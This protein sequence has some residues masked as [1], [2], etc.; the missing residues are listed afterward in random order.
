MLQLQ[1]ETVAHCNAA[2]VFCPYPTMTRKRGV[3][4]WELFKKIAED[5]FTIPQVDHFTLTGLGEPLLDPLLYR[6]IRYL[7]AANASARIDVYTNGSMLSEGVVE[8]LA[9]AGLSDLHVSLNA[10]SATK[11][12]QVM[13]LK[14]YDRV[15]GYIEHA[16]KRS[17]FKVYVKG[18]YSLDLM[19]QG[20]VE[21][22]RDK[23]GSRGIL[24]LEGNWAGEKYQS[25]TVP[26][27]ACHRAISQVMVLWDGRVSLCC[28]DGEGKIIFGDLNTQSIREVFNGPKALE[29][30]EGH[31]QGKRGQLPMCD[32][33]TAI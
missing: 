7:R 20:E 2:C 24:V 12:E 11:R 21:R 1:M 25:R 10:A 32:N 29:Y 19:E 8:E 6:R 27:A 30:R 31:A 28:F 22:F 15:V 26:T 14:D 18:V 5:A 33:C 13:R 4:S 3:M 23:W 9:E 16:I 17:L